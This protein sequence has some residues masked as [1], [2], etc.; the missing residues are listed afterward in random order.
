MSVKN[1]VAIIVL[2]L[3][4]ESAVALEV[5]VNNQP[6]SYQEAGDGDAVV[7]VHG[8]ISD[9]RVWEPYKDLISV[10]R[11]FVSFDQRHF[12][13]SKSGDKST[14]FS[15][16]SH[17]N[18]L[19]IFVE[20]IATA[21]V[22]L[23]SWSYGGDVATRAAI[24]RPDLFQALVYYEPDVNGLIENLPGASRATEKLYEGFVPA[25]EALDENRLEEAALRF[26]DAVFML[27]SGGADTEPEAMKAVWQE[28]SH[29]LPDYLSAP[30]GN[31]AT[32]KIL[33]EVNV[34]ALVVKGSQ[35][36]TYDAMMAE[37]LAQ[38]LPEAVVSTVKGVNHD[39]P[40]RNPKKFAEKI[41]QFLDLVT[42]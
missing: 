31:I 12:G 11:R 20:S 8:A 27:P 32:C 33:S 34:P 24:L 26:I 1:Y 41:N 30:V 7:F 18:D 36:H 13:K 5:I 42:D 14:Q 15:A 25:M 19:I 28:N 40:Y 17:A 21:P 29:T 23:V 38:C 37:R 22:S 2:S 16:D 9:S 35:G 4:M 3:S 39:G 6:L 10:K